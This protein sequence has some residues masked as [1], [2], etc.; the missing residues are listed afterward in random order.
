M[1]IKTV[2][3]QAPIDLIVG[4]TTVYT[5][6]AD[7]RIGISALTCVA[8]AACVVTFYESPNTTSASGDLIDTV[9]FLE[10]GEKDA[11]MVIGHGLEG[12]NLIAVSDAAVVN[13]KL[14]YS[15]Y[16]DDDV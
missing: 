7:T 16:T 5:A 11:S 6:V 10:S 12:T 14:T 1:A 3:S 15:Y 9:T 4:D 13:T 8:T 2:K